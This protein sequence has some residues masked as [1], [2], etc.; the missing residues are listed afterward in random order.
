MKG[1]TNITY[2][3]MPWCRYSA[4]QVNEIGKELE[5]VNLK[6]ACLKPAA[7]VKESK[8]KRAKLHSYFT[9]DDERA[10]DLYREDEARRIIRSVRL[11]KED[12]PEQEQPVVRAYVNVCAHDEEKSFTG[13][14][15]VPVRKA[16]EDPN[17]KQQM[18]DGAKREQLLWL[19]R[20]EDIKDL[21]PD[22][23]GAVVE[24]VGAEG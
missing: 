23:F 3:P 8:P 10:A 2:Q 22:F 12:M 16:V 15:Y 6:H 14:A 5:R 11:V 9:W 18:L 4:T 21:A 1:P 13:H 7:L 19:R 24:F 17:Y 20:Y